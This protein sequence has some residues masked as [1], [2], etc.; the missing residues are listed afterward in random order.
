MSDV[1]TLNVSSLAVLLVTL[2]LVYFASTIIY[3][4][5]FH[6]LARFPGPLAH[7]ATR[8][9]FVIGLFR[10]TLVREVAPL[11]DFYGSVVR[12]APDELSFTDPAAWK[13]IYGRRT[14]VEE[15]PKCSIVYQ[16]RGAPRYLLN[17]T[18]EHHTVLRRQLAP[19]F[20]DRG[21][22][23]QEPLLTRYVELLME[24][25][26]EHCMEETNERVKPK[27]LDMTAW[28]NWATFDVIGELTFGDSFHCLESASYN[29]WI[30]AIIGTTAASPFILAM[31]HL[32]LEKLMIFLMKHVMRPRREHHARTRKKL[33]KRIA[34]NDE[35]TDLIY[36]LLSKK[37]DLNMDIN[38]LHI[39]TSFL[40]V[41]GSETTAAVLSGTT[42]LLL[43][44]PAAL[45]RLTE[46]VRSSFSSDKE[47]TIAAASELT[48]L[49]ACINEALRCYPPIP[50]GLTR[51]VPHG[52]T[53]IA[54]NLI[55]EKTAVSIWPCAINTTEINWTDPLG[56]HPERFLNNE[57]FSAD[58]LDA[59]RPFSV[60]ARDC[61]GRNLANAELRLILARLVFNFD[62]HLADPSVD[63][64]NQ[65]G[66]LLWQRE[67]LNVLLTP[68]K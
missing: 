47:I 8:L 65:K 30:A 32:G 48:F 51:R 42:Y 17:E 27:P 56:Y 25:L 6:P 57:E 40:I 16:T 60:G 45:E 20:N 7:R 35:R 54:G 22:R 12:I 64:L 1:I 58:K 23:S 4:L 55:P 9:P 28:Y 19:G 14:G 5:Y 44:S 50:M 10:R 15:I 3:N 21:M 11:H 53:L 46:E 66:Y 62:I 43:K 29:S 49:S 26:K 18:K 41:A 39:N 34:M 68:A 37:D 67:P 63:W 13:D 59:F 38:C 36:G 33:L 61:I 52:G 31:K 2:T 24:R